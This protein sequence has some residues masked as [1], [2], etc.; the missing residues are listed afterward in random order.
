MKINQYPSAEEVKKNKSWVQEEA[1]RKKYDERLI[2]KLSGNLCNYERNQITDKKLL[3]VRHSKTDVFFKAELINQVGHKEFSQAIYWYR[4][5]SRADFL[6]IERND[7]LDLSRAFDYG[8]IAPNF[9]YVEGYFSKDSSH[10]IEFKMRMTGEKFLNEVYESEK[11]KNKRV[12][13][14]TPKGEGG[15]T[16]GLGKKGIYKGAAGEL[17]NSMLKRGEITWR[18]VNF[19]VTNPLPDDELFYTIK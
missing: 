11:L 2:T 13:K 8:G 16:L 18:L 10:I 4:C 14:E 15:G 9:Q 17:F 6:F 12:G 5:M 19:R 1:N 3:K 7:E